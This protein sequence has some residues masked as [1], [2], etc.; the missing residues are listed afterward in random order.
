[1]K[2][3]IT[4]YFKRVLVALSVL[5]NVLL[6]GKSNQTFS[7]RNYERKLNNNINMVWFIDLLFVWYE[8][9][10]CKRS[11]YYWAIKIKKD[12]TS[13]YVPFDYLDNEL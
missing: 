12:K 10:H 8:S 1:M 7:A 13:K 6:G 4:K 3:K 11:W 9:E 5:L 2:F